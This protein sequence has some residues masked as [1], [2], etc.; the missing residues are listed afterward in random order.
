MKASSKKLYQLTSEKKP[1]LNSPARFSAVEKFQWLKTFRTVNF[2]H[3][4]QLK[5]SKSLFKHWVTCK[6]ALKFM[7]AVGRLPNLKMFL[8][9]KPC[10]PNN[11]AV[12]PAKVLSLLYS[13]VYVK[14]I[15]I[16]LL[17]SDIKALVR[18]VS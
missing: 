4:R 17:G 8:Q 18:K 15:P 2:N 14:V 7:I 5:C 12:F 6:Q 11:W 13:Q 3:E 1:F 16:L 9:K 10:R